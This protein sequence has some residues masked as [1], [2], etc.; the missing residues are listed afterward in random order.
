MTMYRLY[1]PEIHVFPR[2]VICQNSIHSLSQIQVQHSR[3][4]RNRRSG[5]GRSQ[6]DFFRV[7]RPFLVE[8][9]QIDQSDPGSKF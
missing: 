9:K 2:I 8:T 5:S 1:E 6:T 4:T 3:L 7:L